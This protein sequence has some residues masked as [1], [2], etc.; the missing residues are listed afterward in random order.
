LA[1]ADSDR[2]GPWKRADVSAALGLAGAAAECG[3]DARCTMMAW[4]ASWKASSTTFQ[5]ARGVAS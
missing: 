3:S 1:Q 5:L 2:C 4:N